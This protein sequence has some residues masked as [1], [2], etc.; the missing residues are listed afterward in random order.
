MRSLDLSFPDQMDAAVN[1]LLQQSQEGEHVAGDGM[2]KVLQSVLAGSAHA[3]LLPDGTT[4]ALAVDAPS[5]EM[6]IAVSKTW[7]AGLSAAEY[8]VSVAVEIACTVYVYCRHCSVK[9]VSFVG[10]SSK[11]SHNS[12]LPSL[13]ASMYRSDRTSVSGRGDKSYH[14]THLPLKQ[15]DQSSGS[16]SSLPTTNCPGTL[17]IFLLADPQSATPSL[18]FADLGIC[19]SLQNFQIPWF[20]QPHKP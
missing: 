12:S 11:A 9:V 18:Q 6:R 1:Q 13:L 17:Q 7:L 16:L 2:F 10:W 20:R 3:P 15:L 8:C 19:Q 14:C 4:L 5:A